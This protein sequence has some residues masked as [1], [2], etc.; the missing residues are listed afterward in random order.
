MQSV[1]GDQKEVLD[2][3]GRGDGKREEGNR[4]Q[5]KKKSTKKRGKKN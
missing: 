5:F 1:V 2:R 4:R 3:V